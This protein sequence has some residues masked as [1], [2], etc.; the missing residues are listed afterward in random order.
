MTAAKTT[1][2]ATATD[3]RDSCAADL[4]AI[5]AEQYR[6]EEQGIREA[7]MHH[8]LLAS[9]GMV[10]N[11]DDAGRARL[12]G[13]TADLSNAFKMTRSEALNAATNWNRRLTAEQVKSGCKVDAVPLT[14]ALIR[15]ACDKRTIL[16]HV[17]EALAKLA[18]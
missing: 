7:E 4:S 14:A 16:N 15:V 8:V 12:W 18:D 5:E 2:K 17:T 9:C 11:A 13:T 6:I 10:V 3:L 1:V